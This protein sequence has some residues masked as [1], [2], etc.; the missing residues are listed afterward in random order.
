MPLN[1]PTVTADAESSPLSVA[2][3]ALNGFNGW[4]HHIS[5]RRHASGRARLTLT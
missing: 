1:P 3:P 4:S 5:Q 2:G